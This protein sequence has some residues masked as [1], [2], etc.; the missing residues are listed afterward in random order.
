MSRARTF[1]RSPQIQYQDMTAKRQFLA[2][3]GMSEADIDSLL[4]EQVHA[5]MI[6]PRTYP[7]P[8]PSN[9]P[10]LLLGLVRLFSWIGIGSMGLLFVYYRWLY[11]RIVRTV[12]ARRSLRS[13][14][15]SAMRKLTASL[16][17]LKESHSES[18][19]ELPRHD[20]FHEPEEFAQTR[21]LAQVLK[22]LGDVDPNYTSIPPV[23]LLRCAIADFTKGKPGDDFQPTT[24]DIFLLLEG[25]IPWLA[26]D[27]AYKFKGI[28]YD[29][30][31][32]CPRF[33]SI[34]IE[35]NANDTAQQ[36]WKYNAPPRVQPSP[37]IQS[38][39]NLNAA[40]P[41][42]TK[43]EPRSSVFQHTLQALSDF[44]GYISSNVYV[45]YRPPGGMGISSTYGLSPAEE[46]LKKEIRALK[47][48][49]LNRKTFIP[50]IPRPPSFQGRTSLN[51]NTT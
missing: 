25:K 2:A 28:I 15:L 11:P 19:A 34:Q 10:T 23:T 51:A 47:G 5:P 30:L 13:H 8:P 39:S 12:E 7:Q 27:E 4:Q 24:E 36:K 35:A 20:T 40:L 46:A 29:A 48:L 33:E 6:P 31:L 37:V 41:K 43:D 22:K 21:S 38:L 3:K 9:L 26:T 44:T 16:S 1:L 14:H 49:V 42:S 32:A 50:S 45:P 18:L 17:T